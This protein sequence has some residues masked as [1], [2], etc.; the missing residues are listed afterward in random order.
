MFSLNEELAKNQVS[1]PPMYSYTRVL[2]HNPVLI[3]LIVGVSSGLTS[4]TIE[5]SII[6]IMI[7][8]SEP[9]SICVFGLVLVKRGKAC[10]F[11]HFTICY[12]LPITFST[13]WTA[14]RHKLFF[15]WTCFLLSFLLFM[16]VHYWSLLFL[17]AF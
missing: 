5:C 17:H 16:V 13:F 15:F 12:S 8:I 10:Q 14:V 4:L 9:D 2:V 7:I 11:F 6:S 1:K 3:K